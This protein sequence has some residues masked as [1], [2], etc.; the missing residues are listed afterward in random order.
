MYISTL[1]LA[2]ALDGVGGQRHA[3]PLPLYSR[4][5]LVP[6]VWEAAWVPGPVWTGAENLA[7]TGIRSPDRPASSESLYQLR[8]PGP[9]HSDSV[10][11]Y[12]YIDN[13]DIT[14]SPDPVLRQRDV[15]REGDFGINEGVA[16]YF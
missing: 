15:P 9:Q 8:Y 3:P 10:V 12:R 4:K 1:T 16:F 13:T 7:S 6:I 14:Q 11:Q 2:S 5:D